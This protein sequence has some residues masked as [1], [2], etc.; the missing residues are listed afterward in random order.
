MT[1]KMQDES[2]LLKSVEGISESEYA[3]FRDFLETHS[4][5]SIEVHGKSIH[6]YSCGTGPRTILTFAGGWGPPL[7]LYDRISGLEG[8]N[9]MVVIDISAFD[10]LDDMCNGI[11]QVLEAENVER[12]VLFGQSM[13]GIMAQSYFK[14]NQERVE[15]IILANTIAPRI[16]RCKKWALVLLQILPISFIRFFAKK[17]LS[18]LAEYEK[19]IPEDVKQT[20]FFKAVLIKKMMDSYFTKKNTVNTLKVAYAFNEKDGYKEG[21]FE[22]WKGR[23]LIITSEDDPGYPDVEILLTYLPNTEVFKFP[24]GFKHVAPQVYRD[25]F[26][27]EIQRF[28]DQLQD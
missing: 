26:H 12:V 11:N 17:K 27:A 15:G 9:R 22:A 19:E 2:K 4:L 7:M 23:T 1:K 5:K 14:R 18:Q 16:E 24:T 10:D 25:E 6:Y 8:N 13:T 20:M 21:E 3:K 28:I